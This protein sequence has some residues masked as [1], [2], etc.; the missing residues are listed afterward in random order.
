MNGEQATTYLYSVE[1]RQ[2]GWI[3]VESERTAWQWWAIT[4]RQPR[5]RGDWPAVRIKRHFRR[6]PARYRGCVEAV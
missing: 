3:V 6:G 4:Q 5:S 2:H 1:L